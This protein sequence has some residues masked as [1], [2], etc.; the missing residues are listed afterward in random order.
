MNNFSQFNLTALEN[1]MLNE[2]VAFYDELDNICYQ[3]KLTA[4]Q[5]GVIGSLIKKGL[6]YDSF[7]GMEGKGYESNFFPS[8]EVLIA[9]GIE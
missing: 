4:S 7:D 9:A 1:E 5:K 2:I 8:E 6:I 3:Q